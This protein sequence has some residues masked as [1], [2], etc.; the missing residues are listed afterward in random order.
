MRRIRFEAANKSFVVTEESMTAI[1]FDGDGQLVGGDKL[2]PVLSGPFLNWVR[3]DGCV[4]R[5]IEE[6][7]DTVL[8]AC[9]P[10]IGRRCGSSAPRVPRTHCASS[11]FGAPRSRISA[12]RLRPIR[13][14]ASGMAWA[15]PGFRAVR[16]RCSGLPAHRPRLVSVP[17]ILTSGTL[18]FHG[19]E[20]AFPLRK[21]ASIG[22]SSKLSCPST[23]RILRA[24]RPLP[25]L[26]NR[27]S[28]RRDRAVGLLPRTVLRAA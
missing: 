7:R 13:P 22:L 18:Q 17:V 15:T 25:A 14:S 3:Y 5:V 11:E 28:Q 8:L 21:A 27:T 12:Q 6:E 16:S 20:A 9:H 24:A 23:S 2:D 19:R 26:K 1:K 10:S 4:L